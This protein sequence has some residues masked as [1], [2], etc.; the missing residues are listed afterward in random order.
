[1]SLILDLARQFEERSVIENRA[2]FQEQ[3]AAAQFSLIA[4]LLLGGLVAFYRANHLAT[5][6]Q[7]LAVDMD[8]IR[9]GQF[10][11]AIKD[12]KR[13]DEIGDMARNLESFSSDLQELIATKEHVEYL[14]LHDA[15][16]GLRNRRCMDRRLENLPDWTDANSDWL[17]STSIWIGLSLP[18]T[19]TGTMPETLF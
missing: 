10:N 11:V 9:N 18:T 5:S 16:T 3:M 19:L 14:A 17:H 7:R 12:L 6:M 13:A 15:L 1:M 2:K 4:L 8:R